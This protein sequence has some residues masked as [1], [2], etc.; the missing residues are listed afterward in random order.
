MTDALMETRTR[1][2]GKTRVEKPDDPKARE[3]RQTF[4]DWLCDREPKAPQRELTDAEAAALDR[5]YRACLKRACSLAWRI[6]GCTRSEAEDIVHGALARIIRNVVTDRAAFPEEGEPFRRRLMGCVRFVA[7]Q[8]MAGPKPRPPIRQPGARCVKYNPELKIWKEADQLMSR[9][10]V[11]ERGLSPDMEGYDEA[12]DGPALEEIRGV[13]WSAPRRT[14]ARHGP[15][16]PKEDRV[17]RAW[18]LSCIFDTASYQLSTMQRK[19]TELLRDGRTRREI[20]RQLEIRPKT[21]DTHEDRA[22]ETLHHVIVAV[23]PWMPPDGP[24]SP[25]KRHWSEWNSIIKGL[26][27]RRL[28]RLADDANKAA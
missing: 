23:R 21:V 22:H 1:K 25:H 6:T 9:R 10:K 14:T 12:I 8:V 5:G 13:P 24:D 3:K 7:R 28:E 11:P 16:W 2:A 27:A 17:Q 18:D 19:V 26:Q 4:A 20:A 15:C